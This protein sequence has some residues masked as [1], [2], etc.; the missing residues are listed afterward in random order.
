MIQINNS[1]DISSKRPLWTSKNLK[2]Y[3]ENHQ[4][5]E[6]LYLYVEAKLKGAPVF[7][8]SQR[9]FTTFDLVC[10]RVIISRDVKSFST[11]RNV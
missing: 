1:G 6:K 7:K 4:S 3:H 2:K 11:L 10:G 5:N 9:A 8:I